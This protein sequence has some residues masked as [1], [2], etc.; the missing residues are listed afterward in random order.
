MEKNL[1]EELLT[2][3]NQCLNVLI[4]LADRFAMLSNWVSDMANPDNPPVE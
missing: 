1:T 3:I 2:S 4:E